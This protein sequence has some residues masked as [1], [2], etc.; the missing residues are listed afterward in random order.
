M[1]KNLWS[2]LKGN[3]LLMIL[4]TLLTVIQVACVFCLPIYVNHLLNNIGNYNILNLILLFLLF[5]SGLLIFNIFLNY[6]KKR[7]KIYFK[8]KLN[9]DLYYKLFRVKYD[10]LNQKGMSYY[11]EYVNNAVAN[12]SN[13]FTDAIP[14]MIATVLMLLVCIVIIGFYNL[15][16]TFLLLLLVLLQYNIFK[17]INKRLSFK[18]QKLSKV[19]SAGFSYILSAVE[20]LEFLKSRSNHKS[21]MKLLY[22]KIF[23]MHD[24]TEDVNNYAANMCSIYSIF[25]NF[26]QY[27]MLL[28]FG[29]LVLMN[30]LSVSSFV[31]VSII[32][33]VFYDN[34]SAVS[35]ISLKSSEALASW[36]FINE[37]IIMVMERYGGKQLNSVNSFGFVNGVL[38]YD[39]L[40]LA[41]NINLSAKKGDV[42]FIKGE[43][44][45]GKSSLVK[46]LLGLKEMN[47]LKLNENDYSEY[48]LES[49]RQH[50]A[51]VSQNFSLLDDSLLNNILMGENL[52]IDKALKFNF[53]K[54]FV[55]N[56]QIANI[57]IVNKGNNLSGGDKQK[58]VLARTLLKNYDLLI[59]DEVTSS[60]DKETEIQVFDEIFKQRQNLIT[61]IISHDD[62]LM[63]YANR[64]WK[65]ADK[66]FTEIKA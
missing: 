25:V 36:K 52:S 24:V 44:G 8:I 14:G 54:K 10:A 19:C 35:S 32:L 53:F 18:C 50:I 43:T 45:T 38:S 49:I 47:G 63:T 30:Q 55:D 3:R 2:V 17:H 40:V 22:P 42:I 23:E 5:A 28:Y 46:C 26:V 34:L 29:Y 62:H 15:Y 9:E 20:N 16:L 51:Y 58:I 59:L 60:M 66:Q 64:V 13:Y 37:E 33:S 41:N 61:I 65:L 1:T 31:F 12:I 21:L 6:V 39:D 11:T 4:V 48:S 7:F 27:F 57:D 56:G